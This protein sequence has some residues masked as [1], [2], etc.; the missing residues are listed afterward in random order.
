MNSFYP[1]SKPST[2]LYLLN[3]EVLGVEAL[4]FLSR[5]TGKTDPVEFSE[6]SARREEGEIA[7]EKDSIGSD[8]FY[9]HSVNLRA[10]EER[11]GGR[12]VKNSLGCSGNLGHE[13]VEKEPTPPMSQND[14]YLWDEQEKLVDRMEGFQA[15]ARIFVPNRLIGMEKKRNP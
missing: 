8:D 13:F 2:S 7:P 12:V 5:L 4:D 1:I 14:I 10:V 9:G 15:F 3:Q 11:G 6:I